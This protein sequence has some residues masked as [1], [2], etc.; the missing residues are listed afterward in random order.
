MPVEVKRRNRCIDWPMLNL[1]LRSGGGWVSAMLLPLYPRKRSSTRCTIDWVDIRVCLDGCEEK[2]ILQLSGFEPRTAPSIASRYTDY[3]TIMQ[4]LQGVYPIWRKTWINMNYSFST[5]RYVPGT[6]KMTTVFRLGITPCS[7]QV[8]RKLNQTCQ[9]ESCTVC[10]VQAQIFV[11]SVIRLT[12][13][14]TL[15]S[16]CSSV[17]R[18][19]CSADGDHIKRARY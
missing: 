11:P 9:F 6:A 1:G 5:C 10:V 3:A 14:W 19:D 17:S 13:F 7:R 4:I 18:D 2:E 15:C 16:I 12:F 8:D